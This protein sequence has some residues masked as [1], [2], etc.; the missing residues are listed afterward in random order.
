LHH[1]LLAIAM[2]L[3][4]TPA[5][6]QSG[7]AANAATH[8]QAPT[9]RRAV[10]QGTATAT[11]AAIERSFTERMREGG[12]VGVAAAVLVDGKVAWTHGEGWADLARKVPFTPD[13]VMN[14][15]SISKTV[16]GAAMMHAVQDGQLD[17]D[18]DIN[19]YLPFKVVNPAFPDTPITLRQLATHTS[20]ITDREAVYARAYHY[21]GDAPVAL[22]DFLAAYFDPAGA[23]YDR[24][25]F[26]DRM[27]GA[28]RDYSNIGAALAG[29]IVERVSG[30]TLDAYTRERIFVPLGMTRTAWRLAEIPA[31][32]HATLYTL[33]DG[34]P[35]A[36][37][38]YSLSTY[39]DGGVRTSVNDLSRFFLALL[40]DGALDGQR[41][42]DAASA[43]EMLRFQFDARWHPDNVDVAE[44]NSGLFWATRLNTR[45][46]GH[47]GS[48][49]GLKT[50]MLTDP[51]QGTGII[52]F[53]NTELTPTG[54]KAFNALVDALFAY[55]QSL[56]AAAH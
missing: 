37:R 6:A 31:G 26:L 36:L 7:A 51:A 46:I 1:L 29:Y 41:I 42:L 43:R 25:N 38:P 49:P 17:L 47:G 35:E 3:P 20:S 52:I 53:T 19:R 39:P 5:F 28:H 12:L 21:G 11:S 16:T 9:A 13:T 22:G 34:Q 50:E 27:P 8:A 40:G 18:V 56:K 4:G 24:A 54:R 15:A 33:R 32:R 2:V 30:E 23:D 44:L 10:A 55:A 45:L 48:D 14:I